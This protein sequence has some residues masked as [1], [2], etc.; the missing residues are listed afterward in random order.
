MEKKQNLKNQRTVII[1]FGYV[2]LLS[3]MRVLVRFARFGFGSN[4]I[5]TFFLVRRRLPHSYRL[6]TELFT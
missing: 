6:P 3:K 4:P 2:R 1:G 5:S